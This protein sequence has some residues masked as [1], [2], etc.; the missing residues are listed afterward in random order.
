MLYS[1]LF[2]LF[3]V[4]LSSS[5]FTY[6]CGYIY[7]TIY[8]NLKS[9][10]ESFS[11]KRIYNYNDFGVKIK[12]F[13]GHHYISFG[14]HERSLLSEYVVQDA[15]QVT[16]TEISSTVYGH[17]ICGFTQ[18]KEQY[19]S[20]I[21]QFKSMLGKCVY[22]KSKQISFQ[23]FYNFELKHEKKPLPVYFCYACQAHFTYKS[24]NSDVEITP[25]K[26]LQ[27]I[28]NL[29]RLLKNAV[30]KCNSCESQKNVY[31]VRNNNRSKSIFLCAYCKNKFEK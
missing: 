22:C 5:H 4:Y 19:I 21:L 26:N 31:L 29:S 6:S 9:S 30:P 14:N 1:R 23:D 3:L 8:G 17:F 2:F 24:K 10:I 27:R 18:I 28:V 12:F 13:K 20:F 15:D 11:K 16:I 7:K 25:E